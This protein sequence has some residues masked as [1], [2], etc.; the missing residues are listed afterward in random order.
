MNFLGELIPLLMIAGVVCYGYLHNVPVFS[1]FT[2]G[3]KKGIGAAVSILPTLVGI[4][5]GI[6]MLSASGALEAIGNCLR[7]FCELVGIPSEIIPL[8][9]L[10]P[11]SGSGANSAVIQLFTDHGPDSEVGKLASIL[12]SSTETT[13]YAVT[14][15]FAGRNFTKLRY[16]VPVALMGDFC[17]LFFS[18]LTVKLIG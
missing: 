9:L 2:K 4:L 12:A 7:P 14:V 8:A 13:F 11:I 6:T 15:Y 3:A 18:L 16:T 17:A 10:R 1:A 5:A